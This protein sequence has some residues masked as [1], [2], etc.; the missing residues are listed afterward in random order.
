[1]PTHKRPDP[2]DRARYA[3]GRF[4]CRGRC[5]FLGLAAFGTRRLSAAARRMAAQVTTAPRLDMSPTRQTPRPAVAAS[6]A[7]EVPLTHTHVPSFQ[8]PRRARS[9]HAAASRRGLRSLVGRLLAVRPRPDLQRRRSR[10][11]QRTHAKRGRSSCLVH[12][13]C[14]MLHVSWC[15]GERG[16]D[17][18][19]PKSRA[20]RCH[21]GSPER[22]GLQH[23]PCCTA[24]QQA[25]RWMAHPAVRRRRRGVHL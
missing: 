1:M 8:L 18:T 10:R 5:I 2:W 13:A 19:R 20:T 14:C 23:V 21:L 11:L 22:S 25:A 9:R 3:A 16:A 7:A 12:A 15:E 17:L 24:V 4:R 6:G